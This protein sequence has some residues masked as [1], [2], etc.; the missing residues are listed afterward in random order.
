MHGE[1]DDRS[2]PELSTVPH[3]N[4]KRCRH[5]KRSLITKRSNKRNELFS[6]IKAQNNLL[7]SQIN[8]EEDDIDLFF[9]S[10]AMTVKKLPK[11][12]INEAKIQTLRLVN[13]LENNYSFVTQPTSFNI[14]VQS[15]NNSSPIMYNTTQTSSSDGSYEASINYDS[16][17]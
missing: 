11:Q 13:K 1:N 8:Q 9:K 7:V 12:A 4:K 6:K 16:D 17:E 10:I 15:D 2:T 5:E 3:K 14:P